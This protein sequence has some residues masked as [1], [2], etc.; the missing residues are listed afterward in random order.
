MKIPLGIQLWSVRDSCSKDLEGSLKKIKEIGYEGVEPY[1]LYGYEPEEFK[2]ILD[3][4]GLVAL[5]SHVSVY[6]FEDPNGGG[7]EAVAEKYA[8]I[9]VNAIGIPYFGGDLQPG[10]SKFAECLTSLTK[11][12]EALNKY[13]ITLTFH[14]HEHELGFLS[15]GE[16]RLD[17]LYGALPSYMLQAEFDLGWLT[18]AGAD[19]IEY[20]RK[21]AGRVPQVHLKELAFTGKVPAAVA[22]ACGYPVEGED[23][24]ESKFVF[25]PIGQGI[26]PFKAILPELEKAGCRQ[27]IV[28]QD[29][30]TP[31]RD[32]FDC[33]ADS[34]KYIRS[35]MD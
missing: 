27:M 8:K 18:K 13:G 15:N 9:G 7:Y 32:I 1:T 16:R 19:P 10:D 22:K 21:Y 29:E 3:A 17:V 33:V 34:A 30:T 28:E 26:M 25:K 24:P 12:Y 11:I 6:E 35:L 14:N 4:C 5:S 31:G 20:I 23:D 2:R